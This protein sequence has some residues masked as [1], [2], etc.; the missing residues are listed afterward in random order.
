MGGHGYLA[1]SVAGAFPALSV[2]GHLTMSGG[3]PHGGPTVGPATVHVV[4]IVPVAEVLTSFAY[5]GGVQPTETEVLIGPGRATVGWFGSLLHWRRFPIEDGVKPLPVTVNTVPA[6]TPVL[7]LSVNVPTAADAGSASTSSAA[8][9][10]RKRDA[11]IC[12]T[13]TRRTR[14]DGVRGATAVGNHSPGG[15]A[16]A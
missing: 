13:L 16:L 14:P 6:D 12:R 5:V 1:A 7:G 2:A 3:F 11:A 10:T 9:V 4:E 15:D 8:P